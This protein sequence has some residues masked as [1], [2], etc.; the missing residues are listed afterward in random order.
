M[1]KIGKKEAVTHGQQINKELK[2]FF[3]F[4]TVLI[5]NFTILRLLVDPQ[6]MLSN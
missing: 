5:I 4:L 2:S 3:I 1:F 6:D